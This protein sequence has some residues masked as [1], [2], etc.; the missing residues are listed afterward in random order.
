MK[1]QQA[2]K[3]VAQTVECLL[4]LW[5]EGLGLCPHGV[6]EH[7]ADLEEVAKQDNP[8]VEVLSHPAIF[9]GI[10]GAAIA[11]RCAGV[12]EWSPEELTS[13]IRRFLDAW[14]KEATP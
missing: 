13:A 2:G 6:A 12:C 14:I 7:L 4:S 3:V 11:L 1:K 5:I 8:P 10:V 9:Y